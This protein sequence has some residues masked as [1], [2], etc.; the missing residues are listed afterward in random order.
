MA[1]L[2]TYYSPAEI[3]IREFGGIAE[4]AKAIR[5]SPEAIAKWERRRQVPRSAHW[6]IIAAAYLKKMNLNP[7]DILFGR[8][9]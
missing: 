4:L 1:K 8:A 9:E 2:E 7:H 5:R 3:V 6:D